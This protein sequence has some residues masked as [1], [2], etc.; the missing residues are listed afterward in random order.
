MS[1][2]FDFLELD[3]SRPLRTVQPASPAAS[4][5]DPLAA[6]TVA[7][8]AWKILEIIGGPGCQA[9]Q[10]ASPAGLAV[11]A[12]GNL[13]VADSYNHR[14]Q[15]ITPSGDVSILGRRGT[16]PGEFLNP[17]AVVTGSDLGFYVL[18]QGGCRVQRFGP[19]GEWHGAFG[20]RG[21]GRGQMLAPTSMAWGPGGSLFVADTGNNRIVKWTSTTVCVDAY[22]RPHDPSLI[23]PLGIAVDRAGQ[24]WVAETPRHRLLILDAL[25]RPLR[26]VGSEGIEPGQFV[27]PHGLV[28]ASDGTVLVAD[29]GNH[30][31]QVLDQDGSPLQSL[32]GSSRTQRAAGVGS[33]NAP[34]ALALRG[35]DE[36]Y[37]SDT[38]NNRVLRLGREKG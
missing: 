28:V 25:L 30:R 10:F 5:R 8:S 17:Q 24:V 32:L 11:D 15:R 21:S 37:V 3:N 23:R 29:T 22:P 34:T 27:E 31:V 26:T 20:S 16:G 9:G 19:H 18:E 4:V 35:E 38:G 13:Y 7:S 14:V 12:A 6:P 33:L 36:A 2:R 1:D